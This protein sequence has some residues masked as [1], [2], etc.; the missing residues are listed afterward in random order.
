MPPTVLYATKQKE[1]AKNTHSK[2]FVVTSKTVLDL[3]RERRDGD[4]GL[5][6]SL[7]LPKKKSLNP[8]T[9]VSCRQWA[10]VPAQA[11]RRRSNKT[12]KNKKKK[13]KKKRRKEER[14]Q[15]QQQNMFSPIY[16]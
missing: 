12:Q 10:Y 2:S 4:P 15:Q 6:S 8:T 11:R 13:K 16:Y 5:Q 3:P 7:R 14:Q 1:S 9:F